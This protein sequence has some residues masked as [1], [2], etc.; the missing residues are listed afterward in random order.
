MAAAFLL[1]L[2]AVFAVSLGGRDQLLMARLSDRVGKGGG[3]LVVGALAATV[4]AMAMAAA[5]LALTIALPGPAADMLVAIA[6]L[7][8]AFE[9]AWQRPARLPEEPTRSLFASFI[10]LLARQLGD[11]ARF[12]VFAF[13]AGGSAWIAGAGG[14]VGGTAALALG[15][16]LGSELDRWPLRP[17][18]LALAA[19]LAGTAVWTGLAARGIVG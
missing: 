6:L 11:A 10:V 18:R 19:L 12:C 4:S 5:G 3:L 8:A 14:A 2:T 16:A 13:A 7:F 15:I 17:I 9:L 1:A